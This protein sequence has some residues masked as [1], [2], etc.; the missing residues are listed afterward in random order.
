M[1]GLKFRGEVPFQDV[2]IHALVRDARGQKMS[3][4]RGNVIDPLVMID[5]YGAD[6]FRFA[7]TA[8]A[9]QGRDILLSED[10]IQGYRNFTN[11]V[12]N[13]ARFVLMNLD[14]YPAADERCKVQEEGDLYALEGEELKV[15]D[16]W[17][18]SRMTRLIEQVRRALEGYRFNDVAS[19]LYQ[20][21]WHE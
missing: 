20:F 5:R 17:I 19:I 10:R 15:A 7:L 13:A 2:Y 1:M 18:L 11:K 12:W 21:V 4:T 8:F 16:R 3:K 14:G 9:A 6:A